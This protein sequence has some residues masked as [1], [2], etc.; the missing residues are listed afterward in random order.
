S[1]VLHVL[2]GSSGLRSGCQCTPEQRP[3][4]DRLTTV[5]GLEAEEDDVALAD[6]RVHECRLSGDVLGTED[7]A[8]DLRVARCVAG[9]DLDVV[10]GAVERARVAPVPDVDRRLNSAGERVRRVQVGT[11]DGAGDVEVLRSQVLYCTLDGQV[12]NL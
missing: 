4:S 12:Q 3:G 1:S 11:Q 9:E 5:V 6:A 2:R 10:A 7:P 8:G